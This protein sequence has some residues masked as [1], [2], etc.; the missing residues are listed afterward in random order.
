MTTTFKEGDRVRLS[1]GP[2]EPVEGTVL[3]LR[4]D[5]KIT[6]SVPRQSFPHRMRRVVRRPA[7]LELVAR[8]DPRVSQDSAPQVSQDSEPKRR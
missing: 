7:F 2:G 5:G 8:A 4:Q 1:V 6:V 3:L